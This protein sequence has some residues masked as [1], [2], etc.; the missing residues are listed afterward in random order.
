M[1]GRDLGQGFRLGFLK[2]CDRNFP[3]GARAVPLFFFFDPFLLVFIAVVLKLHH[4]VLPFELR[5]GHRF[6]F[7]AQ[8]LEFFFG[9][10]LV[11]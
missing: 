10:S 1:C 4:R 9:L 3:L 8:R 5:L 2:G 7:A 6:N 11:N